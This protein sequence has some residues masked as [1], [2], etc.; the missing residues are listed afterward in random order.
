MRRILKCSFLLIIVSI[1]ALSLVSCGLIKR[2]FGNDEEDSGNLP[3]ND[4]ESSLPTSDSNITSDS[5]GNTDASPTDK[6]TQFTITFSQGGGFSDVKF[7]VNKGDDFFDLPVLN[8]V[9][10]YE[11][12]WESVDLTNIS[13]DIV[14]H[15][16]KTPKI[17]NINYFIENGV[18]SE[19]N[20]LTYTVESNEQPLFAP[21]SNIGAKFYS[22]YTTPDFKEGTEIDSISKCYYEDITLYANWLE[23]EI[24]YIEGFERTTDGESVR[25][26]GNVSSTYDS[27]DLT[28]IVEI[29]HGCSWKVYLD[30]SFNTEITNKTVQLKDGENKVYIKVTHTDKEHF[31]S[32]EVIINRLEMIEYNFVSNGNVIYTGYAQDGDSVSLPELDPQKNGYDFVCWTI[33]GYKVSFPYTINTATTF[34]ARFIASTYE[35]KYS[36]GGGENSP[37]NKTNYTINDTILLNAPSKQHYEFLG[38]YDNAEF[39]GEKLTSIEMGSYGDITLYAKWAP[40]SYNIIYELNG[41][42]NPLANPNSYNIEL[43]VA[44]QDPTRPGCSFR[45]WYSDASFK[46]KVTEIP[47]GTVGAVY[48]YAKWELSEFHITYTLNNGQQNPL[49]VKT[50]YTADDLPLTLHAPTRSNY[51]YGEWYTDNGYGEPISVITYDNI[52]NY[53]LFACYYNISY[54]EK[55]NCYTLTKYSGTHK[56]FEIPSEY[57]GLPVTAIGE[58]AFAYSLRLEKIIFPDTITHV[59]RN[60]FYGC[61]KL[62]SVYIKDMKKWCDIIFQAPSSNPMYN[63]CDL[64]LNNERVTNL[65]IPDTVETIN[66]FAFYRCTSIETAY[67]PG[68]VTYLGGNIFS[69]C[70]SLTTINFQ[71]PITAS[72]SWHIDWKKDTN[73]TINWNYKK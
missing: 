46:N 57:N 14:V 58:E 70:T 19:N 50:T 59:Y 30:K 40:K 42:E 1:L 28:E 18:N 64:Y 31:A 47:K 54:T 4:S 63:N 43:G 21:T 52:G 13:R 29:S 65:V 27:I 10:G 15:A 71:A 16:I 17:Y 53:D 38:W 41:G 56:F 35:I 39:N 8:P 23:Y 22:W 69:D 73:A 33:N 36:L 7:T 66:S 24:K 44:L 25:F 32:F 2:W 62:N 72:T 61:S 26:V 11:I 51:S 67:I 68:T 60:A 20:P 6:K 49:N 45:G 34:D 9:R 48:L 55:N 12:K 3:N 5:N 37:S